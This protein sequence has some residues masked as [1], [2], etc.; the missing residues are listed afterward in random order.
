MFGLFYMGLFY[1]I[2]FLSY[3]FG[4][5]SGVWL[6]GYLFDVIGFYDVVWWVVCGIVII[7]VLL[8]LWID[9]WLVEWLCVVVVF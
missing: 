1:G 4:L 2:V 5:F 8:Y 6:G 7:I 3:Q 9:E